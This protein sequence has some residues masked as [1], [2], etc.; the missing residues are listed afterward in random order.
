MLLKKIFHMNVMKILFI[1]SYK[2][3]YDKEQK[4]P[5]S[6]LDAVSGFL[7]TAIGQKVNMMNLFFNASL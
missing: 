5:V 7:I 4:G 2:V 3:E 1:I 6:A